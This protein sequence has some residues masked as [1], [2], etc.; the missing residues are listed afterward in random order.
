[1]HTKQQRPLRL[2]VEAVW[3]MARSGDQWRLT[4]S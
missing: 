3:Y 4:A 1:M 2:F